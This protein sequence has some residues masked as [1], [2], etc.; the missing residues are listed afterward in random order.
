MRLDKF[1]KVTRLIKRRTVAKEFAENERVLINGRVAKPSAEVRPGDMITIRL[2]EKQLVVE[3]LEVK[4]SA[5][6]S[7]ARNLYRVIS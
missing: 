5:R 7:D 1:L 6:A 2:G 3:V 4:D